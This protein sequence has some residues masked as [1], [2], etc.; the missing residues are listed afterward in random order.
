MQMHQKNILIGSLKETLAMIWKNKSLFLLLL[1]LQIVF[2]AV[3]FFV[4]Y[5]YIPKIIQSVQ[6]ITSYLDNQ[7][8]DEAS[9]TASVMQKKSVLGDDPLSISRNFNEIA[10]NF[11]TYLFYVFVFLAFFISISWT[12]TNKLVHK[13]NYRKLLKYFLKISIISLFCLGLIFFFFFSLMS[14]PLTQIAAEESKLYT[15][16]TPFLAF[17]A[18]LA[19]FMFVS[20]ALANK[21]RLK[22]IVQRTL[23]IGIRKFHYIIPV[24]F[25]NLFLFASSAVLLFYFI[26]GSLFVLFLSLILMIF[27]FAFGRIFMVN[28]VERLEKI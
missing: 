22:N 2:F 1:V 28:V 9:V 3:F 21:T 26:E 12:A 5:A 10:R 14:I 27:S 23:A 4:T 25:I 18:I 20:L 15:K 13:D 17:S 8:L 24:Y 11:K 16:Y 19:Y 7:K 6:S